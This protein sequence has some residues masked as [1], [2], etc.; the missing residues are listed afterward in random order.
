MLKERAKVMLG[1]L[2]TVEV[3]LW[4]LAFF[5]SIWLRN[6]MGEQLTWVPES[7]ID[8]P[9][10][11]L[12][13]SSGLWLASSWA[14][15]LGTSHRMR[16]L[17][18]EL[19]AVAKATGIVF[20]GLLLYV[21]FVNLEMPSRIF[22]VLYCLLAG[23]W[24]AALRYGMRLA[25]R[26]AR[27]WGYNYRTLAVVGDGSLA[28]GVAEM[29]K[30]HRHWG[31]KFVGFI[32]KSE[33]E[34]PKT[35]RLLGDLSKIADIVDDNVI[36]EVIFA[37]EKFELDE[38]EDALKAC[39]E[40]GV[41]TRVVMNFFPHRIS[42]PELTDL[43]GLPLLSFHATSNASMALVAKRV[44]DVVVA[45]TVLLVMSPVL[46]VVGLLVKLTSPGPVFFAQERVGQNGRTFKMYKFR[47]MVVDAEARLK[48]LQALNEMDGPVFKIKNDPRL[49]PIGKFIRK[50]S[51]DEFP[52]FLN[53]L[54]GEMSVVGP[55]PPLPR[56][57]DEYERWQRRRLSVKPGITCTWQ[58]RTG[59]NEVTFDDWMKMDLEYIERWSLYE[60][61]RICARTVPAVLFGRGC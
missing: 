17:G 43:E 12:A 54:R 41:N 6:V 4:A 39:E 7:S 59:R 15:E 61:L 14:F 19:A 10:S 56:E 5:A 29:V 50:T 2:R 40:T 55:R 8:V 13:V 3:G 20:V 18:Q 45:T 31:L 22:V 28:D 32:G 27:T 49:T 9:L 37:V 38:M 44:F 57:V 48:E 26:Q 24:I 36:D 1:A 23:T 42:R 11:L 52:Q 60:D 16:P 58:I 34:K 21:F 25:L 35:G 53:V 30:D 47:S 46:L 51:L 33:T